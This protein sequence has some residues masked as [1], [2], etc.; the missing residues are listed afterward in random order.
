MKFKFIFFIT[1]LSFYF[2]SHAK[3]EGKIYFTKS[4]NREISQCNDSHALLVFS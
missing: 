2:N 1:L 3:S 4:E